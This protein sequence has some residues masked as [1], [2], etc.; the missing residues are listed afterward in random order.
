MRTSIYIGTSL[1]GFIARKDG[2][3]EW[4]VKFENEEVS[5]GFKR[6][7]GKIDAIVMGRNTFETVLGFPDWPYDI[8]VV[9]LSTTLKQ[10]PADLEGKVEI[11]SLGPKDVLN[12]LSRKGH[13]AVYIDGG[14][15]IQSF[16]REDCI[17]EMIITK[18]PVLIGSGISLFGYLENDLQF[19]HINTKK[20]SNGLI[21][22]HY[23]RKRD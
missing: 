16:L 13:S 12:Y 15:V 10:I 2:N 5:N 17:D 18:V 21:T 20:Y 23:K 11:L 6:F 4:L 14:H 9:V 22:S 1:D 7:I 19:E 8:P 3:I